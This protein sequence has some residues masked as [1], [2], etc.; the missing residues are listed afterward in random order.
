MAESAGEQVAAAGPASN[1]A[2]W[3]G[4]ESDPE[5]FTELFR[6]VGLPEAWQIAEV[7]GLEEDLLAFIPSPVQVL[8]LCW[9]RARLTLSRG[10]A[11]AGIAWRLGESR[12]VAQVVSLSSDIVMN[13]TS[14]A[15][16]TRA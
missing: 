8:P 2:R 5:V 4:I 14:C 7:F 16:Q 9:P 11:H 10:S 12:D 13:V 6:K 3:P 15:P 1:R